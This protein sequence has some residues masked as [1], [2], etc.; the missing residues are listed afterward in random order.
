[1]TPSPRL[2]VRVCRLVLLVSDTPSGPS[3]LGGEARPEPEPWPCQR[4][5]DGAQQRILTALGSG[6]L[7]QWD[8]SSGGPNCSWEGWRRGRDGRP[9]QSAG[10][11][12]PSPTC[13]AR[14]PTPQLP[15]TGLP[16]PSP[17][18]PLACARM[19]AHTHTH[20]PRP[21]PVLQPGGAPCGFGDPDGCPGFWPW[22]W[23]PQPKQ[24]RSG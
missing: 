11:R 15:L 5:W 3:R 7:G 1:M 21:S 20:V 13:A 4:R 16:R 24:H 17:A 12:V 9:P 10:P 23:E 6:F 2:V 14:W 19:C 8:V 18:A 22:H